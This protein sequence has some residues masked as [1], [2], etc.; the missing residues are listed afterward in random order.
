MHSVLSSPSIIPGWQHFNHLQRMSGGES[1]ERR[2][3]RLDAPS[4]LRMH[5]AL[6]DGAFGGRLRLKTSRH[7]GHT[8]ARSAGRW[9]RSQKAEVGGQK[10]AGRGRFLCMEKGASK[11][12]LPVSPRIKKVGQDPPYGASSLRI[13]NALCDG[14]FGGCPRR[15]DITSRRMHVGAERRKV[16]QD[17]PYGSPLYGAGVSGS[18]LAV[19]WDGGLR[20]FDGEDATCVRLGVRCSV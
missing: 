15:E 7:V 3:V 9:V 17:A 8:S 1:A 16:R 11:R 6:R 14:A 4:S 20:T 12:T 13:R 10:L 18:V 19:T 5:N 2:R